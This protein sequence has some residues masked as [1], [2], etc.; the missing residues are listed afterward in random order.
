MQVHTLM[1]SNQMLS[2][3]VRSDVP[4]RAECMKSAGFFLKNFRFLCFR[5]AHSPRWRR[6][7]FFCLFSL[8]GL[9]RA[10]GVN[11]FGFF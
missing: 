9:G 3:C 10:C 1:Q 2:D 11:F 7:F 6:I 4:D 8:P 5:R